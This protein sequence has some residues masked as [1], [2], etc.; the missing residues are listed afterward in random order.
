MTRIEELLAL[1]GLTF[2]LEDKGP[3][4][5]RIVLTDPLIP[6]DQLYDVVHEID[7]WCRENIKGICVNTNIRFVSA[8][9]RSNSGN[10]I[11]SSFFPIEKRFFR[12]EIRKIG[13]NVYITTKEAFIEDAK[14]AYE[15]VGGIV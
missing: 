15:R 3:R 1:N 7:T 6:L 4:M 2:T 8:A 12:A 13:K 11:T 10:Y 5:I 14:A 9:T